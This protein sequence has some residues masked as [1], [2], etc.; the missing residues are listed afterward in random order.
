[1]SVT[2]IPLRELCEFRHGNTPSKADAANWGG[3]FP[4]AP[5][6]DMKSD[7][8]SDTLDHITEHAV[9][10][11]KAA[12]A[13]KDSVLVVVRSGILAH[14]FPVAIAARE[15]AFNQ[16]LKSVRATSPLLLPDFLFRFLQSKS[17]Q[18]VTQG[19]KKGATVHSVQSGFL[20]NLELPL[21]SISEQERIVRLLDEITFLIRSHRVAQ[22][23]YENLFHSLLNQEIPK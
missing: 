14:S 11:G 4:W 22:E 17:A 1:M 20:E 5:P 12:I 13:P 18:V 7:I 8:I 16:D 3:T 19:T 10:S 9:L 2:K 21:L 15:I 23:Q 6:K